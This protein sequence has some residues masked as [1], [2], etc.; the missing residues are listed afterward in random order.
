MSTVR[1]F[2]QPIEFV[3]QE[4]VGSPVWRGVASDGDGLSAFAAAV[5][6]NG[7]RIAALW[8]SDER[9][10]GGGFRLHCVFGLEAGHAWVSLD[11][12]AQ[13]DECPVYPDLAGIFPAANRMQRATRDM[14]GIASFGGDQRPWLRHGGWPADWFPL[15]EEIGREE[16]GDRPQFYESQNRGLS[17]ISPAIPPAP[18]SAP[19]AIPANIKDLERAHILETLAKVGGSRKKAVELLGISERT[20][21]YKLAQWRNEDAGTPFATRIPENGDS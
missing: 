15:R 14:V 21:R 4:G 5:H 19:A 18:A 17:P 7:G 13:G 3:E 20:L 6:R 2:D 11:L 9:N 16:I 1:F 12:A 10:R 8:G